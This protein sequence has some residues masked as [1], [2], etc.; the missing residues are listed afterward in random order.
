VVLIFCDNS[1]VVSIVN[2][3]TS[4]CELVMKLV[5]DLFYV[6]VQYNFDLRLRHVPGVLN[7][8]ADL[9]SRLKLTEFREKFP[10]EFSARTS[11]AL[12]S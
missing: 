4:K 2:S 1:S 3:V 10:A 6:A 11:P 12:A 7:V 9:L 5:H 8:P